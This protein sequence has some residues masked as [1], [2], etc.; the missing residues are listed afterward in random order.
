MFIVLEGEDGSGK[1]TQ[2]KLL[3]AWMNEHTA[4]T[5]LWRF[6]NPR[7][8]SYK[9][10]MD[11]LKDG[12]KVLS[13][14]PQASAYMLQSLMV[15]NRMQSLEELNGDLETGHVVSDRWWPS[16]YA[17]GTADG[18]SKV[19]AFPLS[20]GLP[21]ADYHVLLSVDPKVSAQRRATR[22]E[23]NIYESNMEKLLAVS[24]AYR[25]LWESRRVESS[26]RWLVVDASGSV[27]LTLFRL[28]KALGF[29]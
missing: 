7:V 29:K 9:H 27:D 18:L 15:V 10:I 6:P 24:R 16:G 3:A 1:T 2:A 23:T 21:V 20:T 25:E 5:R 19:A 26:T 12:T 17:Y 22:T 4:T 11:M 8:D 28:L 14:D 13:S